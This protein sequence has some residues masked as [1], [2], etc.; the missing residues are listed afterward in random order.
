MNTQKILN[1]IKSV[2]H[3]QKNTFL[4]SLYEDFVV[5]YGAGI[6]QYFHQLRN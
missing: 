6:C 3:L 4:Q 5:L 2:S 1:Y